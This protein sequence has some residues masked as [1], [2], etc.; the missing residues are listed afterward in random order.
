MGKNHAHPPNIPIAL[1]GKMPLEEKCNDHNNNTSKCFY[2]SVD[3]TP[4]VQKS[5]EVNL[6]CS[7][8]QHKVVNRSRPPG[9][10]ASA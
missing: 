8:S 1:K 7:R 2:L 5:R 6:T 9:S 4:A 10:Q 3:I